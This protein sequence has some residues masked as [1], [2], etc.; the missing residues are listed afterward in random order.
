VPTLPEPPLPGDYSAI[1][2]EEG[3]VVLPV[4]LEASIA[5]RL[6]T[7]VER[8]EGGDGVRRRGDVYAVRNFLSVAPEAL[9]ALKVPLVRLLVEPILGPHFF[10][11]GGTVFN[12]TLRANWKVTW[13]QDLSIAVRE[14]VDVPG[15]GPWSIK[16]GVCHVQPP[17]CVLEKMLA[18]RFHLDDCGQD[19]GA[20]RIIPGSHRLGRLS[21]KRIAE[22]TAAE[23]AKVCAVPAGGI[24]VMRPLCLHASSS[25]EQARNRRVVHVE[26]AADE[27]PQPMKWNE[28]HPVASLTTA[29][30]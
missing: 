11:V 26:L 3:V 15:F 22:I 1:L 24:V 7:S 19:N 28:A 8:I 30:R 2:R 25:A 5:S 12:K 6:L 23:T 14:R 16:A 9:E 4:G 27:L 17:V 10:V 18:L 13:H 21:A 29:P 20:L